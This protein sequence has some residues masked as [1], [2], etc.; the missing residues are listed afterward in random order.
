MIDIERTPGAPA[1]LNKK[2][3]W[4]EDDVKEQLWEDFHGKCYLTEMP[5]SVESLSVDHFRPRAEFPT[6]TFDWCN[7]FPVD[8]NANERRP[9]KWPKEGLLDP[10]AGENVEQRLQQYLDENHQPH[11]CAVDPTDLP[12]VNTAIQLE[13]LHNDKKPK[14]AELRNIIY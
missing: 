1:S 3:S 5:V 7:L 8:R 6:L 13:H 14:A 9:K 11:F 12:A 10:S 2:S 4:S